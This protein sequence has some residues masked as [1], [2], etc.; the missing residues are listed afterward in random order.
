MI[1][2]YFS[3]ALRNFQR[4]KSST[5]LNIFCLALG[6]SSFIS[7]Y[8]VVNNILNTDSHFRYSDRIRFISQ[9]FTEI[10][11]ETP[12]YAL[13]TARPVADYLKV[14]RPELEAVVKTLPTWYEA[15]SYEG[16]SAYRSIRFVE[17]DFLKV[18]DLPYLEGEAETALSNPKS[19]VITQ[20]AAEAIFGTTDVVGK[21][22][23][24]KDIYEVTI[25][26][27][28]DEIPS[29]S[30]LS[31]SVLT[32]SG[33]EIFISIDVWENIIR[34][35][36]PQRARI[37]FELER[38]AE[39]FFHT[40]VL[41]PED[42]S[43][44]SEEL[45]L[46]LEGFA[47]RHV[48]PDQGTAFFRSHPISEL[49]TSALDIYL[50]EGKLGI[51]FTTILLFLGSLVL[52]VAALNFV[53]L[54][55]VQN[56]S[57]KK[58][59]GIRKVIGARQSEVV[60]QYLFETFLL[61]FAA[62]LISVISIEI[63]LKF[64]N[65]RIEFEI[66]IPWLLGYE[67][68]VFLVILCVSVT[69][70]SGSYPGLILA[71]IRPILA[72][73]KGDNKAGSNQLRVILIGLQYF[74]ATLFLIFSLVMLLQ[75]S[76]LRDSA[77][78]TNENPLLIVAPGLLY[79]GVDRDTFDQR[80]LLNNN[81]LDITGTNR[82]PW[83]EN[84][85]PRQI[86]LTP[87]RSTTIFNVQR[88]TVSHNYFETMDI[89]LIAGRFFSRDRTSDIE[90]MENWDGSAN[91]SL[92][93]N[94]I[95]DESAV[96][97]FG[98]ADPS[99]AIGKIIYQYSNRRQAYTPQTII[100]VVGDA[101]MQLLSREYSKGIIYAFQ[102]NYA[103]LS[104]LRISQEDIPETLEYIDETWDELAPNT[105]IYRIFM[106]E[107]FEEA[108]QLFNTIY[109][110]LIGLVIFALVI[111][112]MGLFGMANYIINKRMN[113][114]GIRKTLGAN[115]RQIISLLL[116]D[117][118][119]PLLV[120]NLL[121]WPIAYIAAQNYLNLFLEQIDLNFIPFILSLILTI[122]IALSAVT[123]KAFIASRI[124]PAKI[125]RYE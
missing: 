37:A 40:Y 16:N 27:V 3:V 12:D 22:I 102:P 26:S 62:V 84:I 94:I 92:P 42:G 31:K 35:E 29:P 24:I 104:I 63:F 115:R 72:L 97:I 82:F 36:F 7:A 75:H 95:I 19:A 80:M 96:P 17:S 58:E 68:L 85:N 73:G 41:L 112:S 100:G 46:Y 33:I 44:S 25:K 105:P 20:I 70:L 76:S 77:I 4:N 89:P 8:I 107:R 122:L 61:C 103:A 48:P 64:I 123:R 1:K 119:K 99:E 114:I 93:H 66:I 124:N 78:G 38:W 13:M 118:L 53:N 60:K 117:F 121:A 110:V 52:V 69:L 81:I 30:H 67:F 79:A 87:D 32:G 2:H 108:Y 14:E 120:A 34:T 54:A 23:Y 21:N 116:T 98:W 50:F 111:A 59:I 39:R 113:E 90:P 88:R 57:R 106:D 47:A 6:I 65:Q 18:F 86:S 56:I 28:I 91:T 11:T 10:N 74:V 5:L 83:I 125:L 101:P 109:K 55:T 45:D 49:T 15:V 51:S 43:L 9:E 71:R